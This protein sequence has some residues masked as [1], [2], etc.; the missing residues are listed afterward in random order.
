MS[1]QNLLLCFDAFGTLFWP[2]RPVTQQYGEIARQCGLRGFTDEQL[3]N[4]FRQAFKAQAKAHPNYG[5]VTGMGATA[6]WTNVIHDTFRPLAAQDQTPLEE[7]AQRLL[8]RFSSHEGYS[9]DPS[10][11]SLLRSLKEH[12]AKDFDKVVIGVITNSDDRVPGILSS[13]GIRVSPLRY[14]TRLDRS[15]LGPEASYEVD[16]HCMSYDVGFEKPD[17]RIF[18]AAEEMLREVLETQTGRPLEDSDLQAWRKVYVGDDYEKDV[19]GARNA[20]WNAVL[21]EE[22]RRSPNKDIDTLE[23]YSTKAPSVVLADKKILGV[24]SVKAL[25]DWLLSRSS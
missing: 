9:I 14:G 20:G 12:H 10:V 8:H 15:A 6:W 23:E 4:S 21:F 2:K 17:E 13:F 1:K 19:L 11:P 25:V 3:Q 16:F 7:L 18:R 24:R 22:G 5:K